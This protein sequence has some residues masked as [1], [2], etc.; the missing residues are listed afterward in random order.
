[1]YVRLTYSK[2]AKHPTLQIVQGVRQG[3]KVK[4]N[5]IAS[6]GVIKSQNDLVKLHKFA[7]NL[8]QRLEKEGL[9][10]EKTINIQSLT[11]KKTVY[12][13][14]GAVVDK[15]MN[16]T[17]LAGV[18]EQG[19][20]SFSLLEVLKLIITQRFD[21]PSSK[22]RTYERQ[23]EHGFQGIDLQHI[24]RAMDAI[25]P[26]GDELQKQAHRVASA[27]SIEPMDCFFFDVTTLYFE[28]V[29]QDD[30][31]NFGFSKDQ[32]FH[33]TQIV[34]ALV[35]NADGVPIAYDTF[36]GNMAETKT[37]IPVLDALRSRFSIKNTI[38]VCDRG[39]ASQ[40]NIQALQNAGFHFV[41]ATKLRSISKETKINDLSTYTPLPH[42]QN[43]LDEEKVLVRTMEH[44][45]YK[46]TTLIATYSPLR[47]RKDAEDRQRTLEN[48]FKKLGHNSQ[49]SS[50][51]HVIS[52]SAYKKYISVKEGSTISLNENAIHEDASWDGYHGIAVSN[53]AQLSVEEALVRYKGLWQIE[54]AFR[55]AKYTLQTRPIFHWTAPRIK[56]HVLICF[57]ALFLERFLEL[58]LKQANILLTP[59]RIRHALS[60][61]HTTYFE[62]GTNDEG[63]MPSKLP[64]DAENIFRVLG[65][66]T[67]RQAQV[68]PR[69]CV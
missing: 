19:K 24:Y 43:L 39:M 40:T 60:G 4:Q 62:A 26:F 64:E 16:L 2:K 50:V 53:N 15:L 65:I 49:E 69:C 33:V 22:L 29:E 45:Q 54:E 32:K 20:Q 44:P 11:H 7:Q 27:N 55:V 10:I 68:K 8:I 23:E 25:L 21:L 61:V 38:V 41:I 63:F 1:M 6:L 59:D 31:R 36:A 46:D 13:G 57:L 47:A 5:I 12:D 9:P 28:S 67:E 34:L 42:Q 35:A 56:S 30:F 58:R 51:K 14:F 17:G 48:L 37:L 3:S 18:I 66:S 52:N